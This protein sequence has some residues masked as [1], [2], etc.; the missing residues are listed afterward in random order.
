[1]ALETG[2]IYYKGSG[3]SDFAKIGVISDFGKIT[4]LSVDPTDPLCITYTTSLTSATHVMVNQNLKMQRV[5]C[6]EVSCNNDK[7]FC[8]KDTGRV[9]HISHGCS[10]DGNGPEGVEIADTTDM[11]YISAY[12]ILFSFSMLTKMWLNDFDQPYSVWQGGHHPWRLSSTSLE[13]LKVLFETC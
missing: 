12:V 13:P 10:Q 9:T 5:N 8:V 6:L 11:K 7:C 1:M 3:I 4:S 2:E